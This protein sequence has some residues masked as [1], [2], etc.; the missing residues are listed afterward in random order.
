MSEF[1]YWRLTDKGVESRKWY[2]LTDAK[3]VKSEV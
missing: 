3:S 1:E 2:V